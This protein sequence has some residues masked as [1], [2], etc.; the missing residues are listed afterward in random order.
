[1]TLERFYVIMALIDHLL[2]KRL[3]APHY[4]AHLLVANI[5]LELVVIPLLC[6]TGV[7]VLQKLRFQARKRQTL[8]I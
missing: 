1:M 7:S 4:H 5:D 3:S 6:V 2:H 8:L